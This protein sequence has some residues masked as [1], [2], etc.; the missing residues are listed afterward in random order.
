M[1]RI[2]SAQ[3]LRK[4][5]SRSN[6]GMTHNE[7]CQWYC[8]MKGYDWDLH[9]K[10]VRDNSAAVYMPVHRSICSPTMLLLRKKGY[11]TKFG[12]RH[13]LTSAGVRYLQKSGC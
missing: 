9:E 8:E 11:V 4:I 7:I 2:T 1:T 3:L 12:K 6:I 5:H 13:L 10:V